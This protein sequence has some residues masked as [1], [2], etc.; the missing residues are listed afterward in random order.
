MKR[1]HAF[2]VLFFNSVELLIASQERTCVWSPKSSCDKEF[3][4]K[5][6]LQ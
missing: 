5:L 3:R 4:P 2:V 1:L 6:N